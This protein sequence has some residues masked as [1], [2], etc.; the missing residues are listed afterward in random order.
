MILKSG[1]AWESQRHLYKL[2]MVKVPLDSLEKNFKV[3]GQYFLK[4][5]LNFNVRFSDLVQPPVL[6]MTHADIERWQERP[7]W[8]AVRIKLKSNSCDTCVLIT[9]EMAMSVQLLC[10]LWL[11]G[12]GF[13]QCSDEKISVAARGLAGE[14]VL[15]DSNVHCGVRAQKCCEGFVILIL[16]VANFQ[17]LHSLIYCN[18]F[19]S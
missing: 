7:K 15:I 13:L 14:K 5:T 17:Q 4:A 3:Q 8:L 12:G 16:S 11:I 19:N 9:L 6:Q 1:C 2:L 10:S 18:P